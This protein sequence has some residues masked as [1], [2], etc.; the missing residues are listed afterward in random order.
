MKKF[1]NWLFKLLTGYDLVEYED[2]LKHTSEVLKLA[3][4]IHDDN[5]K[6]L[7]LNGRV[8]ETNQKVLSVSNK[9]IEDCRNILLFCSEVNAN[10]TLD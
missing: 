5:K 4:E 6:I 1:R 2:I 7:E 8:I 3:T 10:E 9:A